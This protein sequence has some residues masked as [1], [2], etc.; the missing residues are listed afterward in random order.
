MTLA[1]FFGCLLTA[2]GPG[3]SIFFVHVA[4]KSQLVL[5]TI[6]AAF[7]WLVGIL[8]ASIIWYIA[9]TAPIYVTIFL[10]VFFQELFRWLFFLLLSRA[11]QGLK[12][13]SESANPRYD[14]I[15]YSFVCGLG[16]GLMSGMILYVTQLVESAGPGIL[17]CKSCPSVDVFFISA[18]TTSLFI[19]LHVFWNMVAFQGF[20]RGSYWP[21]AY[22][23]VTHLCASYGTLLIPS[24]VSYGCV[25]SMLISL[26]ILVVT[27]IMA[28]RPVFAAIKSIHRD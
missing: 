16:F 24:S 27:G 11:E 20:F 10:A 23:F 25:Y 1:T 13:V 22:A 19:L 15:D 28:L 17:P 26:A 8:I 14:R 12:L 9:P 2:Y 5:L 4:K 18:L 21:A 6:S 3:L 7:F